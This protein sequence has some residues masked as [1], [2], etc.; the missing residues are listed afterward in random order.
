MLFM[1]RFRVWLCLLAWYDMVW[2]AEKRMRRK[3]EYSVVLI[4]IWSQTNTHS[5]VL[6][7]FEVLNMR[8]D[9]D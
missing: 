3:V 1:I 9:Q 2:Y 8:T 4:G 7:L 5:L 6:C